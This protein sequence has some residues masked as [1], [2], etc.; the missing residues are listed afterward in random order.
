MHPRESYPP[1]R[2]T[3]IPEAPKCLGFNVHHIQM[4]ISR[5][6]VWTLSVTK[7]KGGLSLYEKETARLRRFPCKVPCSTLGP[8][9]L[10]IFLQVV[11]HWQ[12]A[13]LSMWCCFLANPQTW[14]RED[15]VRLCQR[16]CVLPASSASSVPRAGFSGDQLSNRLVQ[17]PL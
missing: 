7:V 17:L 8:K 4:T 11:H 5:F 14:D 13:D 6:G 16:S 10:L 9:P 3:N 1:R 15:S 2:G 12:D